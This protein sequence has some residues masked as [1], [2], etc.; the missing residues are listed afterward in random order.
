MLPLG[1]LGTGLA[2]VP[3]VTLFRRTGAGGS[4]RDVVRGRETSSDG[5]HVIEL[6]AAHRHHEPVGFVVGEGQRR[7]RRGPF[8][9][10]PDGA[11]QGQARALKVGLGEHARVGRF[12]QEQ[13]AT[14]C[15]TKLTVSVGRGGR[16]RV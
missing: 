16:S 14:D 9:E 5:L 7:C 2:F 1:V 6:P 13:T 12:A 11:L 10:R 15:S 4:L 3:M 8:G